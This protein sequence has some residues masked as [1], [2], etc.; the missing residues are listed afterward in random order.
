MSL[1][2]APEG[3]IIVHACNSMGV[4]GSGIAAEFKKR[5]PRAYIQYKT[6]CQTLLNLGEDI[7]GSSNIIENIYSTDNHK[8][9]CLFTSS[10]Y[11]NKKDNVPTII[12]NTAK[13]IVD[14]IQQAID[15]NTFLTHDDKVTIYS[16]KFNS[17]IFGVPWED[18]ELILKTIL[19]YYTQVTWIVCDPD[20]ET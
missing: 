10:G 8:I 3:A 14:I 1:F 17:G 4:W 16:N 7:S 12:A 2:D 11:G 19:K 20:L 15:F 18:S 9:G 6:Y 13:S 5:Y